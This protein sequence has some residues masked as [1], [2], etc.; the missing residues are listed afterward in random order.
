MTINSGQGQLSYEKTISGQ[1]K[2]KKKKKIT[3]ETRIEAVNALT[4]LA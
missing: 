2:K 1:K 4:S 3:K